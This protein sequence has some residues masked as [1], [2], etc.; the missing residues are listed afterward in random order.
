MRRRLRGSEA[1]FRGH[2]TI[3]KAAPESVDSGAAFFK[4]TQLIFCKLPKAELLAL[5]LIRKT[6]LQIC[7]K[8]SSEAHNLQFWQCA[9]IC[10]FYRFAILS[11]GIFT[12]PQPSTNQFPFSRMTF[13]VNLNSGKSFPLTV[14]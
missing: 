14:K 3:K 4:N 8:L 9:V 7:T 11:S 13:I 10:S 12:I 5:H 6:A 1:L 2:W